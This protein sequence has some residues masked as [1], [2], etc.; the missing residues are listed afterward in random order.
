MSTLS[1]IAE[2][3]WWSVISYFHI[4]G[5]TKFESMYMGLS[6]KDPHKQKENTTEIER[7]Y[8]EITPWVWCKLGR[9]QCC[10]RFVC[11]KTRTFTKKCMI[12][13]PD[14]FHVSRR[15]PRTV[16]F[17]IDFGAYVDA[18]FFHK[19]VT[20]LTY[21]SFRCLFFFFTVYICDKPLKGV[22][23]LFSRDKV[24]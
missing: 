5:G 6:P 22:K 20:N 24:L 9:Y 2:V 21:I 18:I 1:D 15:F 23:A 3:W 17:K 19:L 12:W 13:L 10:T 4:V 8:L 14:K 7:L 16:Y 11:P